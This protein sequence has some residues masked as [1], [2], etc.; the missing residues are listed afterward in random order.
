[1]TTKRSHLLF[2]TA[3]A[4]ASVQ[5]NVTTSVVYVTPLILNYLLRFYI[6]PAMSY[7]HYLLLQQITIIM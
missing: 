6:I 5:V 7:K 1:M 2:A 3:D 4:L